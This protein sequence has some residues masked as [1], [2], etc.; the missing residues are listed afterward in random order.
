MLSSWMMGGGFGGF[1]IAIILAFKPN[2]SNYLAPA[3]AVS[4]GFFLGALSAYFELR[5]PGLPMQAALLTF[6][7]LFMLLAA[8]KAG[9]I[10]VTDKFRS[11]VIA[12]TGGICLVYFVS[13]VLGFFGISIPFIHGNGNYRDWF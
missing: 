9:A 5:Y 13:I 7:V 4:E 3:Y 2:L 6:A 1:I 11:G 8:Y 10:Q 12:A